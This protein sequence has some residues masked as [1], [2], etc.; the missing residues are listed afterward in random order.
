LGYTTKGYF[1]FIDLILFPQ[2]EKPKLME[3]NKQA[4]N[5]TADVKL[6]EFIDKK[7]MKLETFFDR[8]VTAEV[9]LRLEK[10]GQVQDKIAEI[11]I[12]VPGS[13][14]VA[15][16]TTKTFEESIDLTASSLKRQL[17]RYKE[18]LGAD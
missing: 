17:I 15:K 12:S 14:L 2:I 3:I 16:E 6:L 4:V 13:V 10:T 9:F 18:K 1:S 8:I 7:I 5:F 11:K